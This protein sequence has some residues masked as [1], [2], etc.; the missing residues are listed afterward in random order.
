VKLRHDNVLIAAF[1]CMCNRYVDGLA[2]WAPQDADAY[3]QRAAFV[4]RDGYVR[5]MKVYIKTWR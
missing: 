5:A 1:F 3:R 4:A 2:T